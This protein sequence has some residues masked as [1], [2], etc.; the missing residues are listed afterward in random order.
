MS[1]NSVRPFRLLRLLTTPL[2]GLN[3]NTNSFMSQRTLR[4]EYFP[5]EFVSTATYLLPTLH[6]DSTAMSAYATP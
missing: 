3:D 4:S 1:E 6:L 2:S 5:F